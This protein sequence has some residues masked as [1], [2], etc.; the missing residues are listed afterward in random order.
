M[1]IKKFDAFGFKSFAE[2]ISLTFPSGI[3]TIVGPNGCGKSNIV[4]AIRWVLGEQG[5]KSLRGK[6]MEDVIFNGTERRKP[7][8][9]AEVALTFSNDN[10][11]TLQ[12][13]EQC[14]EISIK[15]RIFRSGESEYF[16]N[17]THCRLKDILDLFM[18]TGVGTKA[19]SIIGQGRIEWLVNAKPE[20]RR[21]LI[22]EAAGI[23]KYKSRK[24]AAIRKLEATELN[25]VR[26]SDIV[27]EIKRQTGSLQYQAGKARRYKSIESKI[28]D[29]ELYLWT[30][31]CSQLNQVKETVDIELK[32]LKDKELGLSTTLS[33]KEK[34]QEEL[35][36]AALKRLKI[37][38]RTRKE[39]WRQRE[40]FKN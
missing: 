33:K 34:N 2:K 30:D 23:H 16:I 17:N 20:D 25:L 13:Y 1:K 24:E 9:M 39:L 28:K 27:K 37:L 8:G 18:D 15:R 21:V 26:V 11:L 29:Y 36:I 12:G 14:P 4:D 7:L 6:C 35:K 3:T 10:G 32:E 22:E 38:M 19:Y 40:P 5:A 31:E